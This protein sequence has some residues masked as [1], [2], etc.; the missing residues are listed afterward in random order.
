MA[1]REMIEGRGVLF[2]ADKKGNPKKPDFTG[3]ILLDGKVYKLS[4][5]KKQ[6]AYGELIS[7]SHNT[8]GQ[9][10]TQYPREVPDKSG[11]QDSEIPF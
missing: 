6:S 2:T 5:W 8:Y 7:L 3:E 9:N 11:V 4:A 10:N 1:N